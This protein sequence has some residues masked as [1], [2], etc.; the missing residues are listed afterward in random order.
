MWLAVLKY[1]TIAYEVWSP[2]SYEILNFERTL[3]NTIKI[4]YVEPNR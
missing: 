1:A 2:I 3:C 4:R